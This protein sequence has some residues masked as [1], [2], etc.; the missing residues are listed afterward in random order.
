MTKSVRSSC[1]NF[2]FLRNIFAHLVPLSQLQQDALTR[3]GGVACVSKY[4]IEH[5]TGY[6]IFFTGSFRDQCPP[7]LLLL[8]RKTTYSA[9]GRWRALP[10]RHRS[11]DRREFDKD[12]FSAIFWPISTLYMLPHLCIC[13]LSGLALMGRPW[14]ENM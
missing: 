9:G 7:P 12:K 3:H 14:T 5:K 4:V 10:L 6:W 1:Q 2:I 13:S 11:C 8:R